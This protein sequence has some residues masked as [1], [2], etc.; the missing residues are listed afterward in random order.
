[1]IQAPAPL[2]N[3]LPDHHISTA[4]EWGWSNLKNG[5]GDDRRQL[6]IQQEIKM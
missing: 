5:G 3:H 1:M 6:P 4:D 2:W